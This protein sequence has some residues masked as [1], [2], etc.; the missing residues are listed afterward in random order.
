MRRVL[1]FL[2]FLGL[3]VTLVGGTLALVVLATRLWHPGPGAPQLEVWVFGIYF[4]GG[5]LG[6]WAGLAYIF[7]RLVPFPC[8]RCGRAARAVSLNP[9]E[10]RCPSCGDV[11]RI[12]L[13]V[14][15]AS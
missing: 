12:A 9:V 5:A 10:I 7:R 6:G 4:I 15:G 8:R 11:Q 13:H 3:G 14:H 1:R 2:Y